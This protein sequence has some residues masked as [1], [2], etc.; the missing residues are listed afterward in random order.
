MAA[1]V[2]WPLNGRVQVHVPSYLTWSSFHSTMLP[3][4]VI[5]AGNIPGPGLLFSHDVP[6][7]IH[8]GFQMIPSTSWPWRCLQYTGHLKEHGHHQTLL[9]P[10][11][12]SQLLLSRRREE[13]WKA[14]ATFRPQIHWLHSREVPGGHSSQGKVEDSPSVS[15][16]PAS[17]RL[18]DQVP[19]FIHRRPGK[20]I[21]TSHAKVYLK[22]APADPKWIVWERQ[23]R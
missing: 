6:W 17:K 16:K 8:Q 22:R 5:C 12:C 20:I 23:Q 21:S 3:R 13:T 11:S 10:G 18:W 14:C 2:T 19:L 1:Q 9:F 7:T 4:V 15:S